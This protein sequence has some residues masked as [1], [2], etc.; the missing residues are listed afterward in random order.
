[1]RTTPT[2]TFS[3]ARPLSRVGR[4]SPDPLNQLRNVDALPDGRLLG[5]T[6]GDGT[7]TPEFHVILNWLPTLT[8]KLPH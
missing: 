7:T 1:M 2:V 5:V 6:V 3:P 4:Y 8:A